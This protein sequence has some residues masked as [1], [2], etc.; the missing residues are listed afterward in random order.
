M[1]S[2]KTIILIVSIIVLLG[3][4]GFLFVYKIPNNKIES[5]IDISTKINSEK[6]IKITYPADGSTVNLYELSIK[7]KTKPN[8]SI[9]IYNNPEECIHA[10]S[11]AVGASKAN[12]DGSFS[13]DVGISERVQGDWKLVAFAHPTGNYQDL[14]NYDCFPEENK[15]EIVKFNYTNYE[16]HKE[17]IEDRC[18]DTIIETGEVTRENNVIIYE[19]QCLLELHPKSF[20]T[21]LY[22]Y[23]ARDKEGT[24]NRE[25]FRT[26]K[27]YNLGFFP[28][29]YIADDELGKI[30]FYGFN[31]NRDIKVIDIFGNESNNEEVSTFI[32]K[33]IESPNGKYVAQIGLSESTENPKINEIKIINTET[34]EETLYNSDFGSRTRVVPGGWSPDSKSFYFSGG[35]YEF[36]ARAALSKIDVENKSVVG[37]ESLENLYFPV[38]VYPLEGI[39]LVSDLSNHPDKNDLKDVNIYQLNLDDDT[40]KNIIIETGVNYI[41]QITKLGN[42]IYYYA[43]KIDDSTN[44]SLLRKFNVLTGEKSSIHDGQSE[45][46]AV[47]DDWFILQTNDEGYFFVD[48]AS[49]NKTFMHQGNNVA[50]GIPQDNQE[51]VTEII[52]ILESN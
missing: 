8:Y 9:W 26:I 27:P 39:A 23:Y 22:R 37:Y 25:I 50:S 42:N 28:S 3:I 14:K 11:K 40:V 15:S 7:G 43:S 44:N 45:I 19:T 34:Q 32:L 5:T 6:L 31:K 52:G 36:S 13:L 16:L 21:L 46:K 18:I 51:Y 17:V 49:G 20:R 4:V 24:F 1:E 2:K 29:A 12:I 30:S 41:R 47:T 38:L 10:D 33:E 35:I 48:N